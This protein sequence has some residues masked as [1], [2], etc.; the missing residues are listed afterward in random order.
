MSAVLAAKVP[1]SQFTRNHFSQP[2]HANH[3]DQIR[4]RQ[5]FTRRN[6][7]LPFADLKDFCAA[8]ASPSS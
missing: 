7:R 8:I 4:A 2:S 5:A 3:A 6:V 1:I